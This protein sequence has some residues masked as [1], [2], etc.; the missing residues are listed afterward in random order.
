M[1]DFSDEQPTLQDMLALMGPG[2]ANLQVE[3]EFFNGVLHRLHK[4]FGLK[5]DNVQS[6][7]NVLRDYM[8]SIGGYYRKETAS[9]DRKT[10][11]R[12]LTRLSQSTRATIQAIKPFT[13]GS[14]VWNDKSTTFADDPVTYSHFFIDAVALTYDPDISPWK[15]DNELK[16]VIGQLQQISIYTDGILAGFEDLPSKQGQRGIAWYDHFVR[17]LLEAATRLGMS[18]STRDS[19]SKDGGGTAFTEFVLEFEKLLPE[20]G[21][22]PSAI[23]CAKRINRSLSR[24]R[25]LEQK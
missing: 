7:F 23:A 12:K 4:R 25:K 13:G 11:L 8:P 3:P 20:A 9:I 24:L 15:V 16:N 10:L 14:A 1:S 21:R 17:A 22:S 19:G 18:T 5:F 2:T 6:A